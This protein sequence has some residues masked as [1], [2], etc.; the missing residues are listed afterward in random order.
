LIN[1]KDL[2]APSQLFSSDKSHIKTLAF[3]EENNLLLAGY[4]S[5]NIGTWELTVNNNFNLKSLDKLHEDV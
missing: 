3:Y 4:S 5:G 2:Q 1:N